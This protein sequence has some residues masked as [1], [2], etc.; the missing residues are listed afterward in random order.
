MSNQGT[1]QLIHLGSYK[2][3][4]IERQRYKEFIQEQ[5]ELESG[6]AQGWGYHIN[7]KEFIALPK[8]TKHKIKVT[9][10]DPM[11]RNVHLPPSK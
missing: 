3:G 6:T 7:P 4:M 10:I 2:I 1:S 11:K 9:K 5:G 8:T